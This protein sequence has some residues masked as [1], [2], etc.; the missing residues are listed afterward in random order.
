MELA[1]KGEM[2][3]LSLNI[4]SGSIVNYNLR[5]L[6][7][8]LFHLF[9]TMALTALSQEVFEH[10]S[11]RLIPHYIWMPHRFGIKFKYL[12]EDQ[13]VNKLPRA[14]FSSKNGL[15]QILNS[16]LASSLTFFPRC[17]QGRP[18]LSVFP[19]SNSSFALISTG[20][21]EKAE[22]LFRQRLQTD[23][24]RQFTEERRLSEG[25]RGDHEH[26]VQFHQDGH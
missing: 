8:N 18:Q 6:E 4:N 10:L 21:G 12:H 15:M 3:N 2:N 25:E 19:F 13:S 16:N 26:F 20:F 11:H 7:K 1:R 14:M 17:Y 5:M 24:S 23:D 22:T 9:K